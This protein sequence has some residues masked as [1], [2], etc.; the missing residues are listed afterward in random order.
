MLGQARDEATELRKELSA[1]ARAEVEK[2][3]KGWLE[4]VE[5]DRELFLK[6]LSL[7]A[8]RGT[9]AVARRALHDLAGVDLQ[10]RIV[11]VAIRHL[12][13]DAAVWEQLRTDFSGTNVPVVVVTADTL[14]PESRR[15]L[16]RFLSDRGVLAEIQ[17]DTDPRMIFGLRMK[18]GGREVGLDVRG[19]LDELEQEFARAVD[20][21]LEAKS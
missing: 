9:L 17:F 6:E 13:E 14:S 11:D 19:Y 1:S 2:A 21:E 7:Q 10:E 4:S 8:G 3:K 20:A 12:N 5:R 18:S 15:K 16:E